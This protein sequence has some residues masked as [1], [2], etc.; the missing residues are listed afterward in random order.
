MYGF[1]P[2]GRDSRETEVKVDHKKDYLRFWATWYDRLVLDDFQ[3]W[4]TNEKET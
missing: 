4:L 1:N 3:K 2:P